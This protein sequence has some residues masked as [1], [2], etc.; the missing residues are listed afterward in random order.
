[1]EHNHYEF[2][3]SDIGMQ[4]DF[5]AKAHS[6]DELMMKISEHAASVHDMSEPDAATMKAIKGAI[7]MDSSEC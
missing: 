7:R 2:K 3:C 4:C 6:E 5:K 1:M